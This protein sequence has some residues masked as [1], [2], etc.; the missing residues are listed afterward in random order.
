[1]HPQT[2]DGTKLDATFELEAVSNPAQLDLVFMA[3]GS[4]KG[5]PG[6]SNTD[7]FPA[8][9]LLLE[10]LAG[11][12]ARIEWVAVDSGPAKKLDFRDRLV[13]L[14]TPIDLARV[15]DLEGLRRDICTGQKVVGQQPGA[16]GGNSH[17]RI[18]MRLS[19]RKSHLDADDGI[20]VTTG[21]ILVT[22][23]SDSPFNPR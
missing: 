20:L 18:R 21:E 15:W 12:G 23:A 10:R 16:K 9:E 19:L 17:K 5:K 14:N 8:L 3:R 1:M 7:Y 4:S 13:A 2:D 6:S 22:G 11:I